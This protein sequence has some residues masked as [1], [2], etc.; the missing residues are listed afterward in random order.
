M[1]KLLYRGVAHYPVRGH[2]GRPAGYTLVYRGVS[3][4]PVPRAAQTQSLRAMRYRG[5][6]YGLSRVCGT[7]IPLAPRGP[8]MLN[9]ALS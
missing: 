9:G 4:A 8:A 3:H 1:T 2:T 6:A 5:V 7:A